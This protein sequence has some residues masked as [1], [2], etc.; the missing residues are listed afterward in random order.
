M[1]IIFLNII[2]CNW[3]NEVIKVDSIDCHALPSN[4]FDFPCF[5]LFKE[6][7]WNLLALLT[8]LPV[9]STHSFPLKASRW[10]PSLPQSDLNKNCAS[11]PSPDFPFPIPTQKLLKTQIKSLYFI[12]SLT[13][14]FY[15][16]HLK[17]HRLSLPSLTQRASSEAEHGMMLSWILPS[18]TLR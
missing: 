8:S 4:L 17:P 2:F 11:S 12:S 13:L 9:W 7:P 10:S 3:T 18:F 1:C 14:A 5:H 15:L 6:N 16:I